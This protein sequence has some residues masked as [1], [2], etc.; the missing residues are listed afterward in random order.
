MDGLLVVI[1]IILE[2]EQITYAS[3]KHHNILVIAQQLIVMDYCMEQS[4]KL[5]VASPMMEYIHNQDVPCAVCHIVQRSVLMIPGQYT[6][7][8]GWTRE[9]YGYLMSEYHG[10]HRSTYECMDVSPETITGGGADRNGALFHH[11]EA[12]CGSLACPP[13]ENTKELTCAVYSK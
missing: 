13:Y 10:Y 3:Q 6:C 1:M 7:P 12:R 11:V 5:E 2:V 4:M 8:T 9:Y